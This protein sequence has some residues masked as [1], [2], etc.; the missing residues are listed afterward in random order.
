MT[1]IV[2]VDMAGLAFMDPIRS[3]GEDM[4][5]S[6]RLAEIVDQ[7]P[8]ILVHRATM[9]VIDGM[10]RVRAAMLNDRTTIEALFFEGS[11]VAAYNAAI[12]AN[13]AHGLP[14]SRRDRKAAVRHMLEL[15]PD[16]SDRSIARS[17]GVSPTTVAAI[18]SRSTVQN[19]QL[20]IRV[21][22]DGRYRPL[23]AAVG[24]QLAH[25][26]LTD[27]PTISLRALAERAGVSVGTAHDVRERFRQGQAPVSRP[28]SGKPAEQPL[29][30]TQRDQESGGV[31]ALDTLRR[32]PSLRLNEVGRVFLRSL[33][34]TLLYTQVRERL[35]SSLPPHSA[36]LASRAALQ[37]SAFWREIAED[38]Q[39]ANAEAS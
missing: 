29:I 3:R 13:V 28:D 32:D 33:E 9:R 23:T 5:H 25:Q 34:A 19:G 39:Q 2:R 35:L 38:L 8:P 10:H 18:R 37:C 4:A 6:R 22:A 24:R 7:L 36:V 14:L 1:N 26:V 31:P 17:A 21:G 11:D 12:E 20:N 15:S 27:D 16:R 30:P